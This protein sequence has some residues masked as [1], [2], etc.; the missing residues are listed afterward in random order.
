MVNHLWHS[1]DLPGRRSLPLSL[2]YRWRRKWLSRNP[3][4]PSV[5]QSGGQR[6]TTRR[7]AARNLWSR[8]VSC[9]SGAR[10]SFAGQAPQADVEVQI[11]VSGHSSTRKSREL[12]MKADTRQAPS[13]SRLGA[14][15]RN[16]RTCR[17]ELHAECRSAFA[18]P[19]PSTALTSPC[20][21]SGRWCQ[22]IGLGPR[23]RPC[24]S[25]TSQTTAEVVWHSRSPPWVAAGIC[26]EGCSHSGGQI[27]QSYTGSGEAK[28]L[29]IHGDKGRSLGEGSHEPTRSM[30]NGQPRAL[31]RRDAS[32]ESQRS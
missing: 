31:W 29:G 22:P 2:C 13:Q 27:A 32:R 20:R 6:S 30:W 8:P 11:G 26:L 4:A 21:E 15:V 28:C 24:S 12:Q 23:L 5:C 9:P 7:P 19:G 1:D 3:H 10:L 18:L 25:P 16:I 17:V 14:H